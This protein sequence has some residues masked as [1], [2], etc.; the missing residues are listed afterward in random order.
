MEKNSD[1]GHI[2]EMEQLFTSIL[3]GQSALKVDDTKS[4][5]EYIKLQSAVRRLEEY[6]GSPQWKRD[7]ERDEKG[8]IPRDI[9]RGVLSED[10]IY[11]MLERNKE[12]LDDIIR[13]K[14]IAVIFPGIGYHSD[15]PLLYYS[16]K[17]AREAGYIAVE[18]TYEFTNKP[19][20][21]KGNA[22]KMKSAFDIAAEQAAEQLSPLNLKE[23]VDVLF[24]GKSIG[25]AVSAYYNDQN[26]IGARLIVFTPVPQTFDLLEHIT[27][28]AQCYGDNT[29]SPS[30]DHAR[31]IVFH[32]SADPWCDTALAIEKCKE[33]GLPLYITDNANHSLETGAAL[34]DI[35]D[36]QTILT[37]VSNYIK[38]N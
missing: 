22:D 18:V 13:G 26:K 15:K 14:K 28:P 36:L 11:N 32:G 24:I 16:K 1:N 3:Q 30:A 6:Y 38:E 19:G 17:L 25:T 9:A 10:G 27:A 12:I 31:P 23:C 7:F 33:L 4:C 37:T 5:E 2:I 21:I 8:E 29:I 35:A 20:D 34:T